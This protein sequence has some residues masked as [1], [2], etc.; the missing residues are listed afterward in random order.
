MAA[1]S[2]CMHLGMK[3]TLSVQAK[4]LQQCYCSNHAVSYL[5]FCACLFLYSSHRAHLQTQ[6]P[7]SIAYDLQLLLLCKGPFAR[8]LQCCLQNL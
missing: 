3:Q 5:C 1:P 8:H 4:H 7:R 6:L 2:R